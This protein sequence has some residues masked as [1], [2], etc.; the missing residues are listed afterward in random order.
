M[1]VLSPKVLI[2]GIAILVLLAVIIVWS[3]M[4]GS[5]TAGPGSTTRRLVIA[6][7]STPDL[8]DV[9]ALLAYDELTREGYD[10]VPKFYSTPQ[11]SIEAL[12]RGEADILSSSEA[13]LPA[14]LKGAPIKGFVQQ[15]A[16]EWSMVGIHGKKTIQDLHGATVAQHSVVSFGKIMLDSL[17]LEQ[18]PEV[19]PNTIYISGSENRADALIAGT[20]DATAVELVDLVRL[21]KELPGELHV[22]V[23]FAEELPQLMGNVFLATETTLTE[24]REMLKDFTTTLIQSYRKFYDDP[25]WFVERA[26]KVLPTVDMELLSDVME[27]YRK[28][29]VFPINGGILPEHQAYTIEFFEKAQ[30]VEKGLTPDMVYD[31]SILDEV[32]SKIGTL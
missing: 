25:E 11:L 5:N 2:A 26:P 20:I 22:I 23:S 21:Q 31:R 28:Y 19:Q 16:N 30:A 3:V 24:N 7:D 6:Y 18:A 27:L 12:L 13:Y 10:I 29:K 4:T 8:T 14:R 15:I 9:V 17:L 32:L 1:K